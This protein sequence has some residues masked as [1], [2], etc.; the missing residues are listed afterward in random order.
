[1]F[2]H[3]PPA[4]GFAE[5]IGLGECGIRFVHIPLDERRAF[6][7]WLTAELQRRANGATEMSSPPAQ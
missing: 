5:Q 4:P 7:K 6:E 3:R 1:M 2:I